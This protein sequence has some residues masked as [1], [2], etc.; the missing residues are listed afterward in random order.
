MTH[1]RT[2]SLK[3]Y[4]TRLFEEW[5]QHGKIVIAVDFD[6]TISPWKFNSEE[7]LRY[8][9]EVIKLLHD[10]HYTGA[11]IVI[12][13]ACNVDRYEEIKQY[14]AKVGLSIDAINQTPI[15]IPYGQNGKIYAN[16]F[17]DDRAGLLE[18][19]EILEAALY[20]YRGYLQGNKNVFDAA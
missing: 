5:K 17:I 7:D 15:D 10:A 9:S 2:I 1:E 20:Q 16:I 6:D 13:T 4:I 14:C 18:S 3:K 11:Y 12:F 8:Q 19:L